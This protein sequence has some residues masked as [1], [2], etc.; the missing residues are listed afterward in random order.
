MLPGAPIGWSGPPIDIWLRARRYSRAVSETSAAAPPPPNPVLPD[1]SGG[2]LTNVV[3]ALVPHVAGADGV[4]G[5]GGSELPAWMPAPVAGARQV[6][7][8]VLDGLGVNQLSS[9]APIAPV[10]T[11]GSGGVITSVAPSTTAT[12][13]TSL[14]T[15]LAPA[16]HGTV[17]YRVAIDDEVLN[18]LSWRLRD[19]DARREVPPRLFQHH[20]AFAGAP[21]TPVVSRV[22]YL[23]TGFSASH[24]SEA[25]LH[26]WYTPSGLVVEVRRL[27]AG[28][29]PLVYAY[30]D[31]IDRTAHAWGLGEHYDAEL[32]AADRLV[33]DLLES[34]PPGAVLLVTADHGQVEVGSSVMVLGADIM[35]GVRLIS[36]EG[37]FRWLHVRPGALDDVVDAARAECGHVAWVRT[38]EEVIDEGWLG[39]EPVPSVADRLG[40]VVL[41]PFEPTAFLDPA[42][43][44]EQRLVCRHGSLTPDEMLVPLL[45]W[46]GGG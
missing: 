7:L 31:G 3:P 43:T 33:G 22:E 36:G 44:G 4:A 5:G 20:P 27:L 14:V 19:R 12:A 1:F 26:G 29:A 17:G 39:G 13:L 41:A 11:S 45:A 15:G 40:D 8:L 6:V 23:A 21:G 42:D 25:P 32:R 35:D 38:R 24:L 9:R 34:L 2:C 16:V 46:A 30:Y 10:L 18:V 28:G 37:R